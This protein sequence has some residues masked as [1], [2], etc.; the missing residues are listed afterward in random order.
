MGP[1]PTKQPSAPVGPR[2]RAAPLV[3][4]PAH[5]V[6]P[7]LPALPRFAL[8]TRP[9]RRQ[10]SKFAIVTAVADAN[11]VVFAHRCAAAYAKLDGM[12]NMLKDSLEDTYE[13]ISNAC[14]NGVKGPPVVD[15][16]DVVKKALDSNAPLTAAIGGALQDAVSCGCQPGVCIWC[17]PEKT[18]RNG[19]LV[20]DFGKPGARGNITSP[21]A[22]QDITKMLTGVLSR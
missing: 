15:A 7:T 19:T 2:P 11:S 12:V 9:R 1:G 16:H 13:S 14:A 8:A 4:C 3:F 6:H 5:T 22:L 10:A 18:E 20:Y 21:K 17:A